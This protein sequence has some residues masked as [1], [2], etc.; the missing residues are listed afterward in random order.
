MSLVN[1]VLGLALLGLGRKLFWLFVGVGGFLFGANLAAQYLSNRPDWMVL[2]V[3]LV[4]GIVGAVA[5]M[6]L[7]RLAVGVAGFIAGGSVL[8]ELVELL[9]FDPGGLTWLYFLLGGIIG[10]LLMALLFDY[11]LI[12][13]S[14]LVGATMVV[15]AF[16]VDPTFRWL[17]WLALLVGGIL[18]QGLT[19]ARETPGETDFNR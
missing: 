5:A 8:V 17:A 11:A 2:V 15:E 14:S 7:Q 3:A 9:G 13:L 6:F 4:V 18:T 12:G 19:L 16:P 10:G 1:A